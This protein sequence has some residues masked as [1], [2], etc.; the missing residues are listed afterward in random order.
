MKECMMPL[1]ASPFNYF[2]SLPLTCY[3]PNHIPW[4]SL[5]PIGWNGC[6][7]PEGLCRPPGRGQDGR[8]PHGEG[9]GGAGIDQQVMADNDA[10]SHGGS[11]ISV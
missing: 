7:F 6:S 3:W 11:L 8:C 9:G 5:I 2:V 1:K 4:Y 10:V